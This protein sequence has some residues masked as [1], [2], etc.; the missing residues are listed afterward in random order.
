MPPLPPPEGQPAG[1][2][3]VQPVAATDPLLAPNLQK[4][5]AQITLKGSYLALRE[6]LN[7]LEALQIVAIASELDLRAVAPTQQP[8]LQPNAVPVPAAPT[9]ELKLKLSAY[10]RVPGKP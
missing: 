7:K 8:V 3:P 5:S 9:A 1:A 10:S 2:A 4:R 6:F